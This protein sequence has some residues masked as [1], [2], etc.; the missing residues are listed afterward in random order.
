MSSSTSDPD[1][2]RLCDDCLHRLRSDVARLP[3]LYQAC[4]D[5]LVH[6]RRGGIERVRGT[7]ATGL[8]LDEDV[9]AIRSEMLTVAASWA[10]LVAEQRPVAKRP[11]RQLSKLSRFL[12]TQLDWL[13]RHPAATDAAEEI[14]RVARAAEEVVE[15]N[16]S[17]RLELGACDR[18]D[19][20]AVVY[21]TVGTS[22]SL[23]ACGRGHTW[24]PHKWMALAHRLRQPGPGR[25]AAALATP[26]RRHAL[27]R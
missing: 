16:L 22:S 5:L 24:P 18:E 25:A 9:L 21:A 26:G 10:G 1:V 20:S 11:D 4:E 2:R 12:L 6:R 14:G 3:D 13:S 7:R 17:R 23:V 19:C 15:F 8:S 27:S